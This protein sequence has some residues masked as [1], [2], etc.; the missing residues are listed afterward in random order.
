MTREEIIGTMYCVRAVDV[1]GLL[2]ISEVITLLSNITD[3]EHKEI[4]E[5]EKK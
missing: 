2:A 1:D 3:E 5:R 4:M